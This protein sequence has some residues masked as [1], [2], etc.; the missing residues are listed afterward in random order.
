MSQEPVRL[1][2]ASLPWEEGGCRVSGALGCTSPAWL[3][4]PCVTLLP[5]GA[6]TEEGKSSHS[7]STAAPR[8]HTSSFRNVSTWEFIEHLKKKMKMV[9]GFLPSSVV[10]LGRQ[11]ARGSWMGAVWFSPALLPG[12]E[13]A[14]GGSPSL[15]GGCCHLPCCP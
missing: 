6:V 3:R 7:E 1:L 9:L 14:C 4:F 8:R 13:G 5:S 12:M 10:D 15:W 2:E 11:M